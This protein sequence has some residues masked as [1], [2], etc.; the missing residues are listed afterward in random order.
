MIGELYG[1]EDF[2]IRP[3]ENIEF[4]YCRNISSLLLLNGKKGLFNGI[5][6]AINLIL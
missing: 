5:L 3:I 4:I 2:R 1:E 6:P